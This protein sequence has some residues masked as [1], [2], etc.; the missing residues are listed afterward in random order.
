MSGEIT[1]AVPGRHSA[2]TWKQILLPPPV[3]AS[4]SASP[5]AT[6][7]RTTCSCWPRKPRKPNTRRSTAAGSSQVSAC[8]SDCSM[9]SA[10]FDADF[11]PPAFLGGQRE[12]HRTMAALAHPL[13]ID[14]IG[15][16]LIDHDLGAEVGHQDVGLPAAG[17]I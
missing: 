8:T 10:P 1:T 7:W 2:G 4:T 14:A 16:Q 5:P 6:T 3:G 9:G 13:R 17:G 15:L 11:H 12:L